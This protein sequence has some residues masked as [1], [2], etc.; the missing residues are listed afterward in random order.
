M[1]PSTTGPPLAPNF[2][3]ICWRILFSTAS[4][5]APSVTRSKLPQTAPMNAMPIMR[6]SSSGVG[7]C[8]LATANASIVKTLIFLSRIVLRACSGSSLHTA[9]GSRFD[10]RMNVP[11]SSEPAQ[12][13]R[14]AEHLVV[15]RND[16]L[17]VLE[18]GVG[19][20]NRLGAQRDIVVGRR[21]ALLRAV[22]RRGLGVQV[23]G[24]GENVGEQLAGGDG[25]VAADRME[26]DAE[27]R[28]RQ[29]RRVRLALERHQLGLGIGGL[30][31]RL[32]LGELRRR[33]LGEELRA[34]I[35]ERRVARL[36]VLESGDEMA[37]LQVVRAE[38]ENRRGDLG[39]IGE[40]RDAG[41]AYAVD[42]LARLEQRLA[43]HCGERGDVASARAP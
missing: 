30:Q 22:F 39:R 12:R 19:D 37:R 29:E 13:V 4:S 31:L 10:C 40:R 33:V 35:D 42:V 16:Q 2:L 20:Q 34:E 11:P 5:G 23:E 6:V 7:A 24:A 21:A 17:D 32:Q 41:V 3:A 8:F 28:L 1:L 9:T 43:H 18:L 25:A 27:G 26:A 38:S 36:H 14:V 15:G